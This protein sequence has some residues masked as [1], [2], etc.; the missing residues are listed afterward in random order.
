MNV[1]K[2][3]GKHAFYYRNHKDDIRPEKKK[4]E[5]S[6]K[7]TVKDEQHAAEMLSVHVVQAFVCS[8]I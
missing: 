4:Q 1:G 6:S 5:N 8:V 3:Y 7:P 2:D